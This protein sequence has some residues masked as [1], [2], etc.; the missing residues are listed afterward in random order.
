[1]PATRSRITIIQSARAAPDSSP[2]AGT[3]RG[4]P[5]TSLATLARIRQA[6]GD[7][8]GALEA[9]REAEQVQMSPAIVGL[10]NPLPTV[11]ARLALA[12]GEVAE[13]A[14]WVASAGWDLRRNPATRASAST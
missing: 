10:M 7:R 13:A 2:P 8:T 5:R 1:L 12:V 6:R 11:R 9:I 3:A 4:S 14:S